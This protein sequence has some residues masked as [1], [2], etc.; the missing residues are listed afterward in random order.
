M[1]KHIPNLITGLNAASGM[2]AILMALYGEMLWA[3]CFIIIGMIF[4]FFD[5]MVARLLHVKSEMGKELD[6]LADVISFGVAPALLAHLLIRHLLF[7]EG[8]GD[9]ASLAVDER[10]ILFVPLLIPVFSAFRLAKFN[11]DAR[12]VASFIG[13]PTPANA[14]FWVALVFG[15]VYTPELYG[16]WFANIYV[17]GLSVLI[18]SVLL[19]SELPMFSLKIS[20][21][22]WKENRTR[23]LYFISLIV[24]AVWM[25]TAVLV[26]IIPLYVFFAAGEALIKLTS[27]NR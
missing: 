19:V 11:L 3:A 14:L 1:K 24:L 20:G 2:M 10:I 7:P 15:S 13:M 21:F 26:L 25:K 18:L 23:Y 27:P 16:Q 6:S 5:G 17:L 22:G 8:M 4:D 9:I 12:Q